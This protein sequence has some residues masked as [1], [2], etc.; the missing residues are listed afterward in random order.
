[1]KT[2][3]QFYHKLIGRWHSS[4]FNVRYFRRAD[5][6][7]DHYLV[8]AKVGERLEVSKQAAQES[9]LNRFNLKLTELEV[10]K[11]Y[12]INTANRFVALENLND[13]EDIKRV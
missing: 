7:N 8:V 6:D 10:R 13:S 2:P 9:D 12:H 5:C 1:M 11:Q 3:K 4:I